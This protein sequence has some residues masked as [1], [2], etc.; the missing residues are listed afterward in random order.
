MAAAGTY[1]C[2]ELA[3]WFL[4]PFAAKGIQ[5]MPVVLTEEAQLS[6]HKRSIAKAARSMGMAR[7]Q[8]L[9]TTK[10]RSENVRTGVTVL[11]V[12]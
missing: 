6:L 8:P 11:C 7:N 9:T 4:C 10:P 5:I 3:A 12:P 2:F 1:G